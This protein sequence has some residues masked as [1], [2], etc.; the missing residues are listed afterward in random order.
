MTPLFATLICIFGIGYLFWMDRGKNDDVSR[1]VWIPLIWMLLSGS[2]YASQWLSLGSADG[3]GGTE[4]YSEG[5]PLDRGLFM[6]LILAGIWV[7]GMR[8]LYWPELFKRNAWIWLFFFYAAISIF[9]SDDPFLSFKRWVKGG[10]NLVMAL[11]IATERRP[12][13][14]LAFILRRLGFLLIP[15]SVLFIR[16]YPDIGRS[17]HMGSPMFTGVCFQ[18]NSLGQLLVIMGTYFCWEFLLRRSNSAGPK[19]PLHPTVF[20][21]MFL[22]IAWLLYM[23]HS[24][25]AIVCTGIGVGFLLF[26]R[27]PIMVR[28]P[29]RMLGYGLFAAVF[30]VTI[31]ILFDVKGHVIRMLGRE[32]NLTDRTPVWNMVIDIMDNPLIGVGYESFWSGS[33]LREIWTLMGDSS[34]GIIQ[35]HNGYIE[36]YLNL[37]I[38]GLALLVG[39]IICGILK[40]QKQL[41]TEYEYA[42][43]KLSFILVVVINNYTE[44]TYKPVSYYFVLLLVAILDVQY[45]NTLSKQRAPKSV[46]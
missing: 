34:G 16:F 13:E 6:C 21:I 36:V 33:R 5:S 11:V 18:K 41:K 26:C 17:Y 1:S 44:A 46:R 24:A 31:D 28:N 3:I 30:F 45:R 9:W 10:G 42:A 25:T 27:L 7:L 40:V 8:R 38:L 20:P 35:A 32:S 2:R 12:Y 22:M 43:L 14:A 19:K 4:L 15:L 37:G 29:Q 23:A 39:G